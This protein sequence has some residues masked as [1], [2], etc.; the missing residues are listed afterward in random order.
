MFEEFKTMCTWLEKYNR[1]ICTTFERN[2]GTRLR[3][4]LECVRRTGN[5]AQWLLKEVYDDL[6]IYTDTPEYKALSEQN[7]KVRT[8]LK[9]GSLHTGGAKSVSVIVQEMKKELGREST[10]LEISR[11]THLVKKTNESD[12]DVWVEPRA[13]NANNEYIRY[14]SEFGSTQP[15]QEESNQIWIEKVAGGKKEGENLWVWFSK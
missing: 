1:A 15:T 6:C 2:A 14:L 5:V 8:S 13:E 3:N 4:W 11:R 12:P 9:G 10:Q 7:K